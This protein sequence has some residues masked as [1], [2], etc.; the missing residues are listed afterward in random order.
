MPSL[1]A[2]P[3]HTIE[4]TNGCYRA[5]DERE[6]PPVEISLLGGFRV[7]K[8]Q[9]VVG[10]RPGGKAEAVLS[11]LALR[12]SHSVSRETLLEGVWPNADP[13]LAS[14]SLN[15]L[16]YSLHRLLGDA[17]GGA[18][19]LVHEDGTY[20]LNREAG[21]SVDVDA[22]LSLVRAGDRY[23]AISDQPGV[24]ESYARA[25]DLYRGDLNVGVTVQY[26]IERER[27]RATCLTLLARLADYHYA[28]GNLTI[29]LEYATRLLSMDPCREDAHRM[30][31]QC[32][33]RRGERAQALRQFRVCERILRLEFDAAPE[34]ATRALFDRIRHDSSSL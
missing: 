14:Q 2:L 28:G 4:A 18:A 32:H 30:V 6:P 34:Q 19:V 11:V 24:A 27:L 12:N 7:L 10:L 1:D 25:V 16:A 23:A 3:E 15:S 31:M 33:V 21:V 9:Q 29:S 26:V 17:I 5:C 8:H 20:R 22:F 13:H